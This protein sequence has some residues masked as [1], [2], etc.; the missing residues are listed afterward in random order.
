MQSGHRLMT[1]TSRIRGLIRHRVR[2]RRSSEAIVKR[3]M[4]VRPTASYSRDRK[5]KAV[6][7]GDRVAVGGAV[8][9]DAVES[10]RMRRRVRPSAARQEQPAPSPEP[11]RL[12][13]SAKARN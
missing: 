2:I 4:R 13:S 12:W 10:S 8:A 7:R 9:A 5:G 1:T 11:S 3:V 6:A